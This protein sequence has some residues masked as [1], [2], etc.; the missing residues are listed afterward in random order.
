MTV[1]L[2][3]QAGQAAVEAVDTA[4]SLK[5]MVTAGSKGNVVNIAQISAFLGQQSVEGKVTRAYSCACIC[6][7]THVYFVCIAAHPCQVQWTSAAALLSSRRQRRGTHSVCVY[8]CTFASVHSHCW[9]VY[10]YFVCGRRVGSCPIP[11]SKASR[12]QSSSIT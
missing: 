8:V 3:V 7:V 6:R 2:C 5:C 9:V 10:L 1:W 11:T 4:N 12:P